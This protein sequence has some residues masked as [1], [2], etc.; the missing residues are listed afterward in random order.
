MIASGQ[1]SL[2]RLT[3]LLILSFPLLFVGCRPAQN[4]TVIPK[5]WKSFFDASPSMTNA[6]KSNA[7]HKV[8]VAVI[9]TGIDYNHN[10]LKEH[11]HYRLNSS[12]QIIGAGWDFVGNDP[13]PLPYLA[14][15]RHLYNKDLEAQDEERRIFQN[16]RA[17]IRL[18]PQLAQWLDP[19]RNFDDEFTQEIYHGTHVAGLAVYD[20]PR[21]GLLPYRVLPDQEPKEPPQGANTTTNF[22]EIYGAL[23]GAINKANEEGAKVI[24]LSL[25]LTF[26]I[27]DA[28]FKKN[29]H[30]FRRFESLVQKLPH[31]IFVAAAGND[32]TWVNGI[33]R[34]SFPCGIKADN[35]ICVA[36]VDK[37]D[38]PSEFT[39][40]PLIENP[41]IFAPG[42]KI[43]APFPSKWCPSKALTF[44]TIVMDRKEL[45][46]T[47]EEVSNDCIGSDNDRLDR[48]SGTSMSSPLIA[49]ALAIESLEYPRDTPAKQIISK[50]VQK[51]EKV[52]WGPLSAALLKIPLPSWYFKNVES[53]A[54]G[55]MESP[56]TR[57]YFQFFIKQ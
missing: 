4:Q 19:H 48:L 40:I 24:N 1:F 50:F 47:A 22:D 52:Q 5:K 35:M 55:L 57:G 10:A 42:E 6:K 46:K 56:L 3:Y 11:V 33:N 8:L 28:N 31:I 26:G 53:P 29:L 14:R 25:G 21:I 45:E 49:R 27:S 15:T 18:K 20:D 41:L 36:S 38:S 13:W 9:D 17:L 37:N 34:L 23:E 16:A 54:L 44:L 30:F 43:L 32:S 51:A 2:R 39:N 12:G 7:K